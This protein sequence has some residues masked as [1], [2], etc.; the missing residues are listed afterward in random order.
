VHL[1]AG[2]RSVSVARKLARTFA[3]LLAATVAIG[4]LLLGAQAVAAER[5]A[6]LITAVERGDRT[7]AANLTDVVVARVAQRG[8]QTLAA[9]EFRSRLRLT[10]TLE[11]QRCAEEVACLGRAV[12]SLG[13]TRVLVGNVHAEKHRYLF[14]LALHDL[15]AGTIGNRVV[16][17]V[18]GTLEDLIAAVQDTT[19]AMF[20][21][22]PRPGKLL[23]HSSPERA[24]VLVD[25]VFVGVTPM[26]VGVQPGRH[27][28]KVEPE[29]RFPWSAPVEVPA[30]GELQIRLS[31]DHLPERWRWPSRL[32]FGSA[33]GAGLGLVAGAFLGVASE[34]ETELPSRQEA[35][36]DFDRRSRMGNAATALLVCGGALAVLSAYTFLRYRDHVFGRPE[37]E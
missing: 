28:L 34:I 8:H 27:R 2:R 6:V 32:A 11:A 25:N 5:I 31:P 1:P 12:V 13:V 30:D 21:P 14:H 26:E 17:T 23:V 36:R 24:R 4:A 7:L 37:D 35:M 22:P 3:R 18:E 29:G 16:R 9:E 10:S 19:D 20:K 15:A 33:A